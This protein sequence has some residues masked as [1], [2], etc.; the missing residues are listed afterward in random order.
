MVTKQLN[1]LLA[2]FAYGPI[3]KL[4]SVRASLFKLVHQTQLLLVQ[5]FKTFE[6]QEFDENW[7][8][9]PTLGY[10]SPKI[11]GYESPKKIGYGLF[12]PKSFESQSKLEKST[13]IIST[14]KS[15][16][17]LAK[18]S[19]KNKSSRNKQ[20]NKYD[21]ILETIIPIIKP[22]N[23]G[24]DVWQSTSLKTMNS[25][26]TLLI[27]G[28]RSGTPSYIPF[29]SSF[30]IIDAINSIWKFM[31]LLKKKESSIK[32]NSRNSFNS[33][34]INFNQTIK[35]Q[36]YFKP[37]NSKDYDIYFKQISRFQF[38]S[39]SISN[40]ISTIQYFNRDNV[41]SKKLFDYKGVLLFLLTRV[42]VQNIMC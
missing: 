31:L 11:K 27:L 33:N 12:N 13:P 25:G 1:R 38:K 37:I 40:W 3:Q 32:I 22:Y 20:G 39:S 19:M 18:K 21:Y 9:N 15:K 14:Q 16:M 42:S 41:N 4:W 24:F 29:I 2:V 28:G 34:K 26:K 10:E 35:E 8:S 17:I 5:N 7:E 6:S 36:D 23:E 30:S